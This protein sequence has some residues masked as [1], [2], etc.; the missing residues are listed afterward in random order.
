VS[1]QEIEARLTR[2]VKHEFDRLGVVDRNK[3]TRKVTVSLVTNVINFILS[4]PGMLLSQIAQA[5]AWA[6]GGDGRRYISLQNG[7]VDIDDVGR[8][9]VKVIHPHTPHWFTPVRLPYDYDP[10]AA[11]PRWEA[12][13]DTMFAGDRERIEFVREW[14]GYAV[15][16]DVSQQKF[17]IVV[18]Q[19]G[20]GKKVLLEALEGLVG[21]ENCSAVALEDFKSE[22]H[23]SET[24]GKSLNI[25]SEIGDV[26]KLPEGRLKAFVSGDKMSFNRKYRDP[27]SVCPTARL[28]FAT[29]EVPRFS[30]RS[31]G[32]W[33]RLIILPCDVVIPEEK[34]DK[35]LP[36]KIREELPGIFSWALGG[37]A[38][39]RG[40]GF[41][42]IPPA[43]KRAI[44]G[45]RGESSPA[46]RFLTGH[47]EVDPNGQVST[48]V[49]YGFYRQWS[50]GMGHPPISD[51]QFG[52]EVKTVFPTVE[53][54]RPQE[55]GVR[56]PTYCGISVARVPYRDEVEIKDLQ[57]DT[58][59]SQKK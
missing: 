28:V 10:Q 9:A 44:E 27:V 4:E 41:F 34:Q 22:F 53:K 16:G 40:R 57:I 25:V 49:L 7:R 21:A 20:N 56:V 36:Q 5:P 33:R 55:N 32:V 37:A 15:T 46:R 6:E 1:R 30:D 24:L 59:H 54:R 12:F 11:C 17:L 2:F 26:Q 52:N 51:S 43:S 13:L 45:H 29:N 19:G 3:F 48:E 8:G 42:T 47:C 38:T 23:L 39:L 35:N 31:E 58:T 18:G 14:F 50:Q